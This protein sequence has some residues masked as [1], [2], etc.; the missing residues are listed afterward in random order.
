[1]W[2]IVASDRQL[3]LCTQK[4]NQ[5]DLE[6]VKVFQRVVNS[7]NEAGGQAGAALRSIKLVCDEQNLVFKVLPAEV[8]DGKGN[9]ITNPKK[10][11]VLAEASERYLASMAFSG[12]TIAAMSRTRRTYTTRTPRR[13]KT[14]YL[15]VYWSYL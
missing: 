1:M 10:T 12:W 11:A 13:R 9:L 6:Y 8:G 14:F 2:E 4:P 7:I 15:L 3:A 5:S